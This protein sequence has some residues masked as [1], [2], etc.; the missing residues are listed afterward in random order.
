IYKQLANTLIQDPLGKL[1][2]ALL[3]QLEKN[4]LPVVAGGKHTFQL[5]PK[6]L[7]N[8]VGLSADKGNPFIRKLFENK[9]MQLVDNKIATVDVEEIQKQSDYYRKMEKIERARRKA[10]ASQ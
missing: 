8:S 10:A 9:K 7:L 2:D 1:Y 4:R 6:E 5:G 3:M